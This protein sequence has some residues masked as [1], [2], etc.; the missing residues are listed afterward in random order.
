MRLEEQDRQTMEQVVEDAVGRRVLCDGKRAT[1][2]YV[3]TVPP[4]SGEYPALCTLS[5]TNSCL[6]PFFINIY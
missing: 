2:R 1:V 4:T 6:F 5:G 3:G